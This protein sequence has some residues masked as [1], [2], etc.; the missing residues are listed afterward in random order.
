MGHNQE[1]Y[2]AECA[3]LARALESVSEGYVPDR[4]TIFTDAQA[5]IRRMASEEPGPGQQYPIQARKHIAVLRRARPGI[6]IEI[7]WCPA[8]QGI[9]GNEKDD[10]WAKIA[11][12]K[13][14]TRGVENPGP[15]PLSLASLKRE[16]SEK[17]EAR[18]WAGGRI[19]KAKYRVAK[20][21]KPDSEVANSTKRLASR[22]YQLKTAHARIGQYLHCQGPPRCP[23]LAVQVP[24]AN[25][26]PP[27]QGVPGMEGAAKGALGGGAEGDGKVERP[28]EDPG[29]TCPQKVLKGS[30]GL[31]HRYGCGKAGA[32]GG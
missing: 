32:A 31:L 6:T 28:V 9:T 5:A 24:L 18:S 8:H 27:L 29:P 16:I 23:V 12:E 14:C 10:E 25:E 21:Q 7:R 30:A 4:M 22:F 11:A 1:A 3:A 26:R 13:P 15:L 17:A 20:S 19:S 2:N